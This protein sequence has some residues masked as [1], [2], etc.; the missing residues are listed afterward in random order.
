MTFTWLIDNSN[1]KP[2]K[3]TNIQ[4]KTNEKRKEGKEKRESKVASRRLQAI[5]SA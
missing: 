1:K 3:P 5:E 2:N 4:T